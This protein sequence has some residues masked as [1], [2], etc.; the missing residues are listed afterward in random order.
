ME[1]DSNETRRTL[2]VGGRHYDYFSL[3]AAEAMG[4]PGIARLPYTLKIVLEN[5]MRQNAQGTASADDV[6]TLVDWHQ[7]RGSGREIGFRPA[8]VLMPE[9]S[10]ITLLGDLAAMRDAMVHL[11]A[12]PK[13]I[14]PVIPVDFIV[15][16]SVTVHQSGCLDAMAHN[17]D[18]EITQNK[19]RYE[20]LRWGSSA[21]ENLRL[22]PPGTGICH[23]INLEYLAKVVWI[24]P[25]QGRLLAYP[26]SVIG[27]DSHTA[28]INALGIVGWGVGGLDGGAAALGEPISMLIPEV[29]GCRLSGKLRDGV[30]STDLVLTIAQMMRS[31]KVVGKF[32]EYFGP[33]VDELTLPDRATIANMTPEYGATMDFFPID[34]ETLRFLEMTGRDG[35]QIALVEAYS[36][37]QGLWRDATTPIP[38]YSRV[39]EFDLGAVEP[40]VA[41]PARPHARVPLAEA[42]RAFGAAYPASCKTVPVQGTDFALG[43]GNVVIAAITSCTNTSNPSVMIAAGLLARNARMRGLKTKPWVKTSLSPGS[44]VVADYLA[45]SGL[46]DFLDQLGF[47]LTGFGCMTCMGNSGPL[48][49]PIAQAIENNDLAAVAVLSGNRNF[50]GRI[51]PGVRANFLASP[52]LVVAYALSGSISKDLVHEPLGN[53]EHGA[54]VY[55][56]DIWPDGKEIRRIIARTISAQLFRNRYQAVHQ[57][58]TQWQQLPSGGGTIYLWDPR[59]TFIRRPPFFENMTTAL[60]AIQDIHGARVLAMFGDM[61]TTDHISPIGEIPAKTP[62]GHYLQSLGIA[63]QDFVNYAARRLNHDVMTRGTFANIRIRNEMT[64]GIEGSSTRHMPDGR[65]MSIFDAAE[66]Y[67]KEGVPLVIVAGREYGAGSSRDW[68]AKGTALLGMRAVIAESFERIHRSNLVSMGVL[69]LQFMDGATHKTLEL[70]GSEVFDIP[71]LQATL[72]P[73][74]QLTCTMTRTSGKRESIALLARLDTKLEVEYYRHGGI[75]N[76]ALRRRII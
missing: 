59:S 71:G 61:L 2:D 37:A 70:D 66:R 52:P 67:R 35:H 47:H 65:H 73:G 69:P 46:Q 9:S 74:M 3:A 15:D 75:L 51:H 18:R 5:L 57:G 45:Q 27:M 60:P 63:P 33:G 32:V 62:A 23:Q 58:T 44:R 64:P 29:I 25:D 49:A 48:A 11:G 36:K 76:Y 8:R 43:D 68:A 41:G 50:E 42:P 54:P 72:T 13:R 7:D 34:A 38:D 16:H 6:A 10:G 1:F 55:L 22:F 28:M 40:C 39:I 31:H 17:M 30:T 53:D 19:E 20:F 21:F 24:A 56:R 4:Y 12:D 26:D 14:N